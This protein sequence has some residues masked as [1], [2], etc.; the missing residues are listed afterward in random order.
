MNEI[1]Y[2]VKDLQDYTGILTQHVDSDNFKMELKVEDNP[3]LKRSVEEIDPSIELTFHH[4]LGTSTQFFHNIF[5]CPCTR[6][7][8]RRNESGRCDKCDKVIETYDIFISNLN[9]LQVGDTFS[10]KAALINNKQSEL[11]VR[12]QSFRDYQRIEVACVD[13]WLRLTDTPEGINKKY[14][15]KEQRLQREREEEDKRREEE[16][17]RRE[18]EDKRK[19][20]EK[21]ERL[22]QWLT[23]YPNI[24]KIGGAILGVTVLN[25]IDHI[26]KGLKF[27]FKL[28]FPN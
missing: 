10:I 18:E 22:E 6:Q 2:K 4:N 25:Q 27:L 16:D 11:P 24:L 28:I 26:F 1:P 7:S 21:W 12:I 8:E 5:R 17:K 9:K 15:L 23:K 14:E 19:K 20:R 3:V 13:Y